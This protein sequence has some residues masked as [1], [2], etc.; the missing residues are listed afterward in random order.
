MFVVIY[1]DSSSCSASPLLNDVLSSDRGRIG[2]KIVLSC[3]LHT[4][5]ITL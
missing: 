5:V 2:G 1:P 4:P 3:D